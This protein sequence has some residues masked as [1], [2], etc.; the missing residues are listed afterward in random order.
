MN[1]T[2]VEIYILGRETV[3]FSV[4]AQLFLESFLKVIPEVGG[5]NWGFYQMENA[6]ANRFELLNT[7][8][9]IKHVH[10]Q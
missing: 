9:N 10:V 5:G 3:T 6:K 2:W 8:Y 1:D 7:M 4:P